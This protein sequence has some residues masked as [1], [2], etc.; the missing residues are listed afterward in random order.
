[1]M[2]ELKRPNP[3][4]VWLRFVL[5]S[6]AAFY[7]DSIAA[8]TVVVPRLCPT[9]TYT[10]FISGYSQQYNAINVPSL[11]TADNKVYVVPISA[12]SS[13]TVCGAAISQ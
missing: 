2:Y 9:C 12:S 7:P 13:P 3:T 5:M 1:M 6:C 4:L 8:R 10:A 11:S